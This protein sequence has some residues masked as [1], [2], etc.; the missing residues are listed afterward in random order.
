M[1]MGVL[2]LKVRRSEHSLSICSGT[3][4]SF[5][6]EKESFSQSQTQVEAEDLHAQ[7]PGV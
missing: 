7:G 1:E 4:Q 5:S 6:S 2:I 3:S